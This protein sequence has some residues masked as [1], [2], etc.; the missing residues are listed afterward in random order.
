[1]PDHR[2]SYLRRPNV[3]RTTQRTTGRAKKRQ[4]S[5]SVQRALQYRRDIMRGGSP[6]DII[7]LL[8]QEA[9]GD[10]SVEYSLDLGLESEETSAND[11]EILLTDEDDMDDYEADSTAMTPGPDEGASWS[12]DFHDRIAVVVTDGSAVFRIPDWAL[13]IADGDLNMRW[14]TYRSIADWLNRNCRDFLAQPSFFNLVAKPQNLGEPL[15]VV[16]DG[17]HQI[18]GLSC[19]ITTFSKHCRH[20]IVVWPARSILMEDLWSQEAKMAWFARAVIA[21][22]KG[23]GYTGRNGPL[24]SPTI[25]PPRGSIERRALADRWKERSHR[26]GPVEFVELLCVLTGC[27]WRDVLAR[28]AVRI[29]YQER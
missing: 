12:L 15:P 23:H 19:E 29:F 21:R 8:A 17:L 9:T 11:S 1:M 26:M 2:A 7:Q 13:T 3:H 4:I 22:Q 20:G 24:G 16:Q 14:E 18:L 25:R 10:E 6:S 5:R 28:Y 27:A